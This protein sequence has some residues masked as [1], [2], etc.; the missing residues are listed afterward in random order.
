MRVLNPGFL[1]SNW[2]A[3]FGRFLQVSAL[4]FHWLADCA[5]FTPSQRK[6]KNTA[7]ATVSAIKAASQT[8][9]INEQLYSTCD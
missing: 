5:N 7:P 2:S 9:F 3:E 6:T 8:T 1:A 4:A